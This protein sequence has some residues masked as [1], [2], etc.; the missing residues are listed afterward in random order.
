MAKSRCGD[1]MAC[2][3]NQL[4]LKG[5]RRLPCKGGCLFFWLFPESAAS[6]LA[7]IKFLIHRSLL[8]REKSSCVF[9]KAMTPSEP[10]IAATPRNPAFAPCAGPI[11]R[12]NVKPGCPAL[13]D[14]NYCIPGISAWLRQARTTPPTWGFLT[15]PSGFRATPTAPTAWLRV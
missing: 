15:I 11:A 8:K 13:S 6:G 2:T 9:P 14:V 1:T 5:Q 12:A 4:K 7:D 3:Q 10:P